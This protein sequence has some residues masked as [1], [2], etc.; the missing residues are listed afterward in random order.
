MHGWHYAHK[1]GDLVRV[2]GQINISL[3]KDEVGDLG[4]IVKSPYETSGILFVEVYMFKSAHI[5]WFSPRE[6]DIISNIDDQLSI[7]LE[8]FRNEADQQ[9]CREYVFNMR[10]DKLWSVSFCHVDIGTL[11]T[12]S[13]TI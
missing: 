11:F 2:V 8:G 7:Y 3:G 12:I 9:F 5:R 13:F 4:I 10:L 1:V 6:I